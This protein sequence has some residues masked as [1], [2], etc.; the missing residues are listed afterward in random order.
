M[1]DLKTVATTAVI[2][3]LVYLV[4]QLA[5]NFGFDVAGILPR[6]GAASSTVAQANGEA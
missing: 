6:P 4:L 2:A 1:P 5:A 3:L